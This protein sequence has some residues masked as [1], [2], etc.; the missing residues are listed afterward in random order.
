[1]PRLFNK[2]YTTYCFNSHG[3]GSDIIA[4][5]DYSNPSHCSMNSNVALGIGYDPDSSSEL[6]LNI[7][8]ATI[9]LV[10]CI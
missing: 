6:G 1:M 10:G 4:I 7:N 9:A 5:G 3:D 8:T 2:L